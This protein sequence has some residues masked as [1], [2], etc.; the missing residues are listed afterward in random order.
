MA[1]AEFAL[2]ILRA[3]RGLAAKKRTLM[4]GK[5]TKSDPTLDEALWQIRPYSIEA[6]VDGAVHFLRKMA[7]RQNLCVVHGDPAPG[8]DR[9]GW[10]RRWSSES[11]GSDRTIVS[12]E[13]AYVV[14]D[15]DDAPTPE[16]S[17]LDRGENIYAAAEY[18][19]DTFL[20]RAFRHVDLAVGA[21][22][23]TGFKPSRL[24]LHAYAMLDRPVPLSV[25]NRYLT[26]AQKSGLPLDPRPGCRGSS[27]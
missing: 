9:H 26:G 5:T 22:S 23:S 7:K 13:R 8:L 24:S 14:F 1:D 11:R 12:A 21:A 3:R 6:D 17:P 10:H 2:T 25:M 19:R 27:S 18:A 16:G 15:V 20:P 4:R